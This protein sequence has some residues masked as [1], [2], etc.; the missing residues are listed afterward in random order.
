[1]KQTG[2]LPDFRYLNGG[3]PRP[4]FDLDS[5]CLFA[6]KRCILYQKSGRMKSAKGKERRCWKVLGGY[7]F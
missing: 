1:M 3:L 4:Y 6:V 7:N 2:F 5:L